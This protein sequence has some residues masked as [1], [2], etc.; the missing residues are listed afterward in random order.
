MDK[1]MYRGIRKQSSMT[2]FGLPL[3]DISLGPDIEKNE[4]RGY[5]NGIIAIGDIAKGWIAIGGLAMG[6]VTFGGLSIGI[7]SIGGL[8]LGL[9][10]LGGFS[11]GAVAI[12][13][14]AVGYYAFGGGAWGKYVISAA[15]RAP[16]AIEFFKQWFPFLP[17]L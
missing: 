15:K 17:T 2:V 6:I 7:I 11:I 13:G 1:Q 12:G 10:A 9:I 8:S 3:I 4:I 16:E 5:A 14:G